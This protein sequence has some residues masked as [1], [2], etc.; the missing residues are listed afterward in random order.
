MF[1]YN[2]KNTFWNQ[3]I[4][5]KILSQDKLLFVNSRPSKIKNSLSV[6]HRIF[7]KEITK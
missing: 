3:T 4:L 7:K 2:T 1:W 5:I 6:V